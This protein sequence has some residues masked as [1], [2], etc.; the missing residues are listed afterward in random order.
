M[1]ELE[2]QLADDMDAQ[3]AGAAE[4]MEARLA[5]YDRTINA[6]NEARTAIK[7]A[8]QLGAGRRH[9][10][11]GAVLCSVAA[12]CP[13]RGFGKHEVPLCKAHLGGCVVWRGCHL[14]DCLHA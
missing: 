4:G 2:S 1:Q 12:P 13:R 5:L 10:V 11:P 8:T 14:V 6:Y 7:A 3:G 9:A